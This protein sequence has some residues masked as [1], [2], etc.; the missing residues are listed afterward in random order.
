MQTWL[1]HRAASYLSREL[2]T[3]VRVDR[4]YF[5]PFSSLDIRG[6]LV[7][8]QT[9]DTLL[10][11]GRLDAEVSLTNLFDGKLEIEELNLK[12]GSIYLKRLP[13]STSN[14]TFL[15]DY[16]SSDK[17]KPDSTSFEV[18]L[19]KLNLE[20]LRFRYDNQLVD[21]F[22][23]GIDFNHLNV[24][25]LNGRFSEI[26]FKDHLIAAY[27]EE[28]T[29]EEQSGFRLYELTTRAVVDSN[30]MDFSA[31]YAR[32]NRSRLA[33]QVSFQFDSFADFS[34]FNHKVYVEGELQNARIHSADIAFFAPSADVTKF[35][36]LLSG[37]VSGRV[38][39]FRGRNLVMQTGAA[40]YMKGNI[41][42]RG[43]PEIER[44]IFDLQLSQLASNKKDLDILLPDLSGGSVSPLPSSFADLGH[45]SYSGKLLGTYRDF[46]IDGSLK[47]A[48]GQL[49]AKADLSLGEVSH[50]KGVISSPALKLGS[51]LKNK[52]LGQVSF[53]AEVS[54][55]GMALQDLHAQV[56]ST[57]HSLEF[58]EYDYR[59]IR[60][61]G[62]V[63]QQQFDGLI[64]AMDPHLQAALEGRIDLNGELPVY[65]FELLLE[66]AELHQL[67]FTKDSLTIRTEVDADFTGDD[68]NNM[69][70]RIDFRGSKI[71]LPDTAASIDS[72]VISA[73]GNRDRRLLTLRSDLADI[74]LRGE[75][76]L[77][78]FPSYFK[79]VLNKYVPSWRTNLLPSEQLFEVNVRL[80]NA[81]PL[82]MLFARDIRIPDTAVFNGRFS[83][84]DSIASMNGYI[85]RL[86]IGKK[87]SISKIILDETALSNS[88]NLMLTADQWDITDSLYVKN[89]NISNVL[90]DDSLHFNLKL[91]DV[92]AK[93][94]LDL[95]ALVRFSTGESAKVSLLPSNVIINRQDWELDEEVNFDFVQNQVTITG[96][97]LKNEDQQIRIDGLLSES[98]EESLQAHF[99]NFSL[100]NLDG[101]L[102][103]L[104]IELRGTLN[105]NVKL[106]SALKT[107]F[108]S[109]EME[110]SKIF[111]NETEIGDLALNADMDPGTQLVDVDVSIRR[112]DLETLKIT[113]N[114]NA[115]AE[116]DNLNLDVHL[117][118]SELIIFEPFLRQLVTNLE[119]TATAD[120]KLRGTPLAP[121]IGGKVRFNDAAFTVIYLQTHYRVDQE[122]SVENSVIQLNELK[123]LDDNE[124][125]AIAT[126]TVDMG[127]P[128]DPTIEVVVKADNFMVLNTT[129]K[130][131][132]LYYG[133]AFGT[134]TFNFK[135]PTSSM[136]I[137]ITARTEQGTVF[138]IP[139]NSAGTVSDN[140]FITFINPDSTVSST[141][142]S[143]FD[144]LT[145]K[146]NLTINS[147]AQA[148][149]FTD[150]GKL[151]GTGE[152]N[153]TMNITSLGDFEMFGDYSILAGKFDFTARDFINKIFEIRR[154][155][156]IRWT[157]N[158]TEAIINLTAAYEVRTSAAPLYIA[159]GRAGTD[160][161]VLAQ[162][163]MHLSGSL[164]HP[165]ISFSLD[166]P[167]DAYVKD[168]LQNYFSD[169][170]NVN[171]QA[172][173]LIVRRGFNPGTGTDLTTELNTT[174]FRAGTEL[175]FNQLNNI[176]SQSLNL[177]FVDLNIR[178]LNEA[179]A[180]VRLLNNRLMIMGELTDRR[181]DLNDL[182]VFGNQIASD[183]EALYLLRKNGNLL[184]R[185]SNRLNNRN[186]LNPN[187]EYIS[188]FG[189]VYRQEFDTFKE[190]FR[191]M[192]FLS[193]KKRE[194]EDD[195]VTPFN[196]APITTP[197]E[198]S[199]TNPS[200]TIGGPGW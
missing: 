200:T 155:G 173:S 156:T 8:D 151:S 181:N 137:D 7:L 186:F 109:S 55:S 111:Y 70:G 133:K 148:N 187:D 190:F 154:G 38:D 139:L 132:E 80:K 87:M 159:A 48:L 107:P 93:N 27:V 134:G 126:G 162:A 166:F 32:T 13:D 75:I 52:Q 45:I 160:Q 62:A 21:T 191:R 152:G 58:N 43:L 9:Q 60:I 182:N 106:F 170:N 98:T 165:D 12:D 18:G 41:R 31:L 195:G 20:G 199:I 69:V 72:M 29:L 192:F 153:L 10:R 11:L 101:L 59:N 163:G 96:F 115:L 124:H 85:P 14:V 63:D 197:V 167:I 64:E 138:N 185:A 128:T 131:N 97:E 172:L 5:K 81:D 16:F 149:L 135:G 158:P 95:N 39:D 57:I 122:V 3:E 140:E 90:A 100:E 56:R 71:S 86:L 168:E 4:L 50:Y 36:V 78:T 129:S 53:D 17:P 28:L 177:N 196:S 117:E 34:D 146:L 112:A 144:G 77:N 15:T 23:N 147:A 176:I 110:A 189:I 193:R 61:D 83:S 198:P 104:G 171:Q 44:T 120:V 84:A 22:A 82:S 180:T 194:E 136:D 46:S 79:G 108:V 54:G 127:N 178:S 91:S 157:G 179:S 169:I 2:R 145:M 105:G 42:V 161:R 19:H 102:N 67:G 123:L 119:G 118:D 49:Q 188:A 76:D 73:R 125:Q 66:K 25:N 175:A 47:S 99:E 103:P 183:V 142:R 65:S 6:L 121:R 116:D 174:V 51:L 68:L 74:M 184:L 92:D 35:N 1:T 88:L 141:R 143:Y 24:S 30:R 33:E 150:L 26:N 130:D 164:T 114:Y 89:I 37:S 113:G 40:T 94:Q